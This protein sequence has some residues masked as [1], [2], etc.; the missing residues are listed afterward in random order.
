MFIEW[1]V[2]PCKKMEKFA[3]ISVN[4][5]TV[6]VLHSWLNLGFDL[7]SC[8]LCIYDYF[9]YFKSFFIFYEN[10]NIPHK[11]IHITDIYRL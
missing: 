3:V 4:D 1:F 11:Q 10:K 9:L 7:F 8:K 6:V 2:C 5:P